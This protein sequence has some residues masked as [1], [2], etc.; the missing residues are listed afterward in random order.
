MP[1]PN[2]YW[3]DPR[4]SY[5]M[6]PPPPGYPYGPYS[7]MN[8]S[9]GYVG[10]M[11]QAYG[12]S[13]FPPA[14]GARNMGQVRQSLGSMYSQGYSSSADRP[15]GSAGAVDASVLEILRELKLAKVKIFAFNFLQN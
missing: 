8:Q 6:M 3:Q 5:G 4:L 2:I 10:G 11:D 15:T 7:S 1:G 9:Q 12:G 14:F 13:F